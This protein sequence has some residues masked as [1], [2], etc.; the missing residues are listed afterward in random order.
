MLEEPQKKAIQKAYSTFLESNQLKARSGQKQMIAEIARALGAIDTDS[1]GRRTGDS[2][3]TVIE[4]GTGTGKT[5]GYVLPAVVMAQAADKRLVIATAT[6]TLQ[7]QVINKDLPDIIAKTG[8]EFS[9]T[10]A[11]GR[12]RYACLSKLDRLLQEE[13]A[14]ASLMDMFADQNFS[15]SNDQSARELYQKMLD[16]FSAATW[17]GDRDSW[18]DALDDAQWRTITTDHAQCSGRRCSYFRHCPFYQARAE[19]DDADVVVANHDLVLADLA[20]GGGAILPEPHN[21]I[22]VFDEGHHLPDK[23][24]DHFT[25]QSRVRGTA[26]WLEKAGRHLH[27]TLSQQ[28]LPGTLGELLERIQPE[29]EHLVNDLGQTRQML[30]SMAS[31]EPKTQF[32]PQGEMQVAYYRFPQGVVPDA[33]RQQAEKLKAGFSKCSSMLEKVAKALDEAMDGSTAGID[34]WQAEQLYPDVKAMQVRMESHFQLWLTYTQPDPEGEPPWARWLK[35]SEGPFG[36]ELEVFSSPI[37]SA[38]TLW[39]TLWNPAYGAIVTSATLAALGSF[40]RFRMRS[41]VPNESRCVV[42]PSPFLHHQAATLVVPA[43][44]SDPR[45][46]EEHTGEIVELLPTL[47]GAEEHSHGVLVLFSSRRQMKDVHFGLDA[48]WQEKILLQDD[49]SRQELLKQHR[50]RIDEGAVSILFGLASLAEGI[51]LPGHYCEHVI[52]AKIPFAVPDDPV[53]AALSEW[54]EA[55]G[56][57]PFMEITVPD[58]AIRLIQACGRLLRTEQDRGR[59]TIMDRRLVTARYGQMIM[60]SLPPFQ[61][62]IEPVTASAIRQ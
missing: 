47:F 8:L 25:C 38:M 27:K 20:L 26:T 40:G 49:Y 54:L 2:S 33:L 4:A 30:H 21:T 23:A 29:F 53:E 62:V 58:A 55:Q 9:Y 36:E 48:Q 60:N 24:I 1:E 61:R 57:N 15:Q 44:T 19:L 35:W 56:R 42:V 11:K 52:I 12:G 3:V 37:M 18:P 51:D 34:R 46:A 41:G 31:F 22:Y 5:V 28:S 7:E 59:I 43:M 10:L 17:A 32:T 50:Q 13:E 14:T 16:A 6:V 45:N 39:Q